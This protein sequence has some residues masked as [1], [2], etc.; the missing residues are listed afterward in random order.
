MEKNI[1]SLILLASLILVVIPMVIFPN[2]LGLPLLSA[3]ALY[4]LYEMA[5]YGFVLYSFRREIPLITILIGSALTMVFRMGLGAAFGLAIIIMYGLDSSV[6]FSLGMGKYLPAIILHVVSAPFVLRPAYLHLASSL[7]PERPK[8][9]VFEPHIEEKETVSSEITEPIAPLQSQSFSEMETDKQ[10][11]EVTSTPQA[12]GD[13]QL[14]RAVQY[15]GESAAVKMSLLIDEEGLTLANFSRCDEDIELWAP[16][17]IIIENENRRLLN[18]FSPVGNP[19]KLDIT[20]NNKR[21]IMRRI[22]RFILMVMTEENIDETI[23][24]R[25]AQAADMI[26]KYINERYS[27]ALFVRVEDQYVSNS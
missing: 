17:A 5:F 21:I 12:D 1:K 14:E 27:P 6:A 7:N 25:M 8:K 20:T 16:A 9:F 11:F 2:K 13:N 26:R 18:H 22:E 23:H 10:I 15:I 19:S 24:I 3:S 4:M